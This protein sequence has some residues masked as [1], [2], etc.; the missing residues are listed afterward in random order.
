MRKFDFGLRITRDDDVD[1]SAQNISAGFDISKNKV[2]EC[3]SLSVRTRSS[4]KDKCGSLS[5]MKDIS[6]SKRRFS[7]VKE[8]ADLS[9]RA[10]H[11]VELEE[12][13]SACFR[14]ISKRA[15]YLTAKAS[16]VDGAIRHALPSPHSFVTDIICEQVKL[17]LK[18][19][20]FF[21]ICGS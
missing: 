14:R 10:A 21:Y 20:D 17:S 2:T 13:D 18:H 15:K 12:W 1:S 19:L 11:C 4:K 8:S 6:N 3:S 9:L 7:I 5:D 16:R